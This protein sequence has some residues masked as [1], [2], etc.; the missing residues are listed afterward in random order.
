MQTVL[1]LF[2][3]DLCTYMP[4][5]VQFAVIGA[6]TADCNLNFSVP[7]NFHPPVAFVIKFYHFFCGHFIC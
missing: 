5:H 3:A 6:L 7:I 4:A 2:F 1:P